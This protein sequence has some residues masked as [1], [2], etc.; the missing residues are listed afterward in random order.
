MR[1]SVTDILP[2]IHAASATVSSGQSLLHEWHKNG[3]QRAQ[4]PYPRPFGLRG[5]LLPSLQALW[6]A[7]LGR[8]VE[9]CSTDESRV[10]QALATQLTQHDVQLVAQLPA[11]IGAQQPRCLGQT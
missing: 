9:S 1:P 6:L 11:G 3:L 8:S 7:C 2:P 5:F 10:L 4:A